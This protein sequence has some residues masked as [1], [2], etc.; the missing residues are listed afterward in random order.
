M[1]PVVN[2]VMEYFLRNPTTTIHIRELARRTG[3]TPSGCLKALGKLV[4]RGFVEEHKTTAVSNYRANPTTQ[5]VRLKKVFNIY[6]IFDSGLVDYLKQEYEF[7]EAIIVFGSYAKGE[8]TE[9]SDIDIA[10][11]TQH[12]KS[13]D[14]RKYESIL[15]RK[16]NILELPNLKDSKK[17][18]INNLI[19]GIVLEGVLKL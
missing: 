11:I 13:L 4:K 15:Q 2:D 10:I 12:E 14:F 3:V 8:D 7:P 19:N 1:F 16:I 9:Q 5:F 6:S 17:E 18:F